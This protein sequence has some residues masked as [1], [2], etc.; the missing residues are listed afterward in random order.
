LLYSAML[1]CR[2][3]N[4]ARDE[5]EALALIQQGQVELRPAQEFGTVTP[6]AAVISPSTSLVEVTDLAET[7]AGRSAWSLLGSG[8]G[9]QIRFGSRDP[10][11]LER[12]AWRDTVL[13][14]SLSRALDRRPIRLNALAALGLAGGDDMHARTSAANEAL[15]ALLIPALLAD[16]PADVPAMLKAS[17]LFFL[18]LWMAACHLMLDSA[19]NGGQDP[20][21]TLVVAM[22]GNGERF[23]IRLA[24]KPGEW[25]TEIARPP[26]GPR[27]KPAL[28]A[29]TLPVIGDSGVI[30]ALG[31][32]AQAL[33]FAPEIH[34]ALRSWLPPYWEKSGELLIG[35][36]PE[37]AEGNFRV[38]MD[39]ARVTDRAPGPL[40]AIAMLDAGGEYGLLG[41]GLFTPS[42]ELFKRAACAMVVA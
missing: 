3:E 17:P 24:G 23:G 38:G 4:W 13:A 14:D 25:F 29:S 15:N 22:A 33:N 21:S 32:G 30:D 7:G 12:M 35:R 1:C 31:F 20:A 40:A 10:A 41:R 36:H 19:A 26:L 37:F 27:L 28:V 39:A 5:A 18:T 6:L 42:P 11:I 9:P 8:A 16:T 2:H 34:E